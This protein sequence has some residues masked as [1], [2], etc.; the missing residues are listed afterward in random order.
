MI[1]Q[2]LISFSKTVYLSLVHF[3]SMRRRPKNKKI[4]FLLSF[5]STSTYVVDA[6]VKKYN[7]RL[8]ICY[9]NNAQ[10]IADGYKEK[11]IDCYPL[12]SFY[13]LCTKIIP[14]I[15]M[16]QMILCDNYFA[17]LGGISF[18]E[19]TQVVQIWH[20]NG[21]IKKFG[22]QAQYAKKAT[23]KDQQRYQKVYDTFTHFV[24]SSPEMAKIFAESY[25][26]DPI[27]L[28]FGYPMTDYYFNR[29]EK[30]VLR[31]KTI[32]SKGTNKKIALYVPTYRE[33]DYELPLDFHQVEKQIG[34]EWVFYV[35][36]H[37]HDKKL[38]SLA[39]KY[40]SYFVDGTQHDLKD[41]IA[42]ADCLI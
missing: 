18:D 12:Q 5:P 3:F 2:I 22:L 32:L 39:K 8:I 15:K 27:F 24:V 29:D 30:K 42:V 35:H 14:I 33:N 9:T 20:A 1:K 21:A 4:V 28:K 10:E 16:S 40:P 38:K 19:Q 7:N 26:I 36:A 25:N 11:G 34:D 17:F 6:L 37:P 13:T 31:E 23:A 41:L